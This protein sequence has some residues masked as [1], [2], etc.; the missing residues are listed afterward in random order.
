MSYLHLKLAAAA[1]A[2]SLQP[3]PTLC[4]PIDGSPPGSSVHRILQARIPEWESASQ[5]T[6]APNPEEGRQSVH[7][8]FSDDTGETQDLPAEGTPRQASGCRQ[9][10]GGVGSPLRP[11]LL[12]SRWAPSTQAEA[13][14]P[15]GSLAGGGPRRPQPLIWPHLLTPWPDQPVSCAPYLPGGHQLTPINLELPAPA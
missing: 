11:G 10:S 6:T 9:W 1:A 8:H 14:P 13:G 5:A 4:D 15:R 7:P 12:G 2:K 3:C